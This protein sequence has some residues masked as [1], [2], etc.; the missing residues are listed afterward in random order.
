MR[1]DSLDVISPYVTGEAFN[2]AEVLGSLH[3]RG[4]QRG[5]RIMTHH[6]IAV[7]PK[8]ARFWFAHN[9]TAINPTSGEQR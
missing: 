4:D 9:P 8:E 5:L 2:E 7:A 1:Y 3:H 6:S